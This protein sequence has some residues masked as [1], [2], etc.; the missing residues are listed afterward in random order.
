M[1]LKKWGE[2]IKGR[3]CL[4][5]ND[6]PPTHDSTKAALDELKEGIAAV[7]ED[8]RCVSGNNDLAI[9]KFDKRLTALEGGDAPR[10]YNVL[11]RLTALEKRTKGMQEAHCNLVEEVVDNVGD[12]LTA[13]ESDNLEIHQLLK[14][15]REKRHHQFS[16]VDK[17]LSKH[18]WDEHDNLDAKDAPESFVCG[19]C[20]SYPCGHEADYGCF[21]PK[22]PD[23][24]G[25]CGGTGKDI[26]DTHFGIQVCSDC[27]GTGK[28]PP[29]TCGNCEKAYWNWDDK[30]FGVCLD[31]PEA[32]KPNG[33]IWHVCRTQKACPHYDRR[34]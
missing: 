25:N 33:Q 19:I 15:E 7:D 17:T 22:S 14:C 12:R 4:D 18:R 9:H 31:H 1:E 8:L 30:A 27:K 28:Q 3:W 29:P 11:D 34:V 32:D 21:K 2:T 23:A 16:G 20:A 6:R 13:M 24:C 10:D 5:P 26:G